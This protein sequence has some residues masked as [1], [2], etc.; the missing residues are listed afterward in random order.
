M[1]GGTK[2]LFWQ[3]ENRGEADDLP[4]AKEAKDVNLVTGV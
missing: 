3:I 2:S 1:V 4:F